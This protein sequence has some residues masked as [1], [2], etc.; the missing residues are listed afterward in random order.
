MYM[1]RISHNYFDAHRDAHTVDSV[2]PLS[3][4]PGLILVLVL[5][6]GLL[7]MEQPVS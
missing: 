2:N 4:R 1:G 3:V 7:R 6:S 5:D